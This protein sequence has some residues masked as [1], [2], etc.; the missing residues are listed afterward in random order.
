[1]IYAKLVDIKLEIK[2]NLPAFFSY[3][4]VDVRAKDNT[5]RYGFVLCF[6]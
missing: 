4:C 2:E 1:M 6:S 5:Y 3:L